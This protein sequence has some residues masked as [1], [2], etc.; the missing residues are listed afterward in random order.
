MEDNRTEMNINPAEKRI[1]VTK[2]EMERSTPDVTKLS[3]LLRDEKTN[4]L[5]QA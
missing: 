3:S 1:R 4:L 2:E 5:L